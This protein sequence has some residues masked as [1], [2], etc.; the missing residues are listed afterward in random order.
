[1][2][3]SRQAR[4]QRH[5][6]YL[7]A[8]VIGFVV[9]GFE[10]VSSRYLFPFF[11]SG[12]TTWGSLIATVLTALMAGYYFGGSLADRYP[13]SAAIG[14][15]VLVAAGFLAL[16]PPF[17]LDFLDWLVL[18]VPDQAWGT[19]LA[20]FALTFVPVFLLGVFT[21]FSVRLILPAREMDGRVAGRIYALSTFGNIVGT[22]ATTFYF[23]PLMGSR[24]ITFGFAACLLVSGLSLISGRRLERLGAGLGAAVLLLLAS[25]VQSVQSV[26]A[27]GESQVLHDNAGYPEGPVWHGGKLYYAEMG[28]D[29]V[30]YWDGRETRT[31]FHAA[32]CGPTS[33]APYD[34]GF[35]VLCHLADKLVA[36]DPD[37]RAQRTF[38]TDAAGCNHLHVFEPDVG[39]QLALLRLPA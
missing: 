17:A 38:A 3:S 34:G 28:H 36:I 30:S 8:F 32:G 13:S 14:A 33:I 24:A 19:L 31:L 11:G 12:V 20:A 39:V 29:K 22:L 1:M 25:P 23:I 9:M 21:P 7:N 16:I 18:A 27:A 15:I 37:G 5:L 4:N 6:I 35:V 2:T 26:Q 10:M